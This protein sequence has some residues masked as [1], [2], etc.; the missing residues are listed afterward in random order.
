[1]EEEGL[2]GR[3]LATGIIRVSG[4]PDEVDTYAA[5]LACVSECLNPTALTPE[6][7]YC[8][9]GCKQEPAQGHMA[10]GES[11]TSTIVRLAFMGHLPASSREASNP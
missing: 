4:T 8:R 10:M 2:V 5:M 1:M 3:G 9:T 6:K 11:P 7:R